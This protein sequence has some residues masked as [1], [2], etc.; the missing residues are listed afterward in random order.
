M[1]PVSF[2]ASSQTIA[3]LP[4]LLAWLIEHDAPRPVVLTHDALFGLAAAAATWT[5]AQ[6]AVE[7]MNVFEPPAEAIW[8]TG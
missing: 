5:T 3:W 8:M 2:P 7:H 6:L 1:R 4:A